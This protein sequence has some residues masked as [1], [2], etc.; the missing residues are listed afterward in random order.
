M[1][2]VLSGRGP[3]RG[4]RARFG[5][6]VVGVLSATLLLLL[7]TPGLSPAR[8]GTSAG[9]KL[10]EGREDSSFLPRAAS[11]PNSTDN[12]T[13][14]LGRMVLLVGL[15]AGALVTLVWSRV[16]V[17]W[18]SHDPSRK[19]QAKERARDAAI[20]SFVLLAAVSGLAWGLARFVL[21]GS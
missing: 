21:T 3:Q 14:A 15:A 19:V 7:L 13:A 6:S 2:T 17:S 8:G 9:V 12:L 16:A 5:G 20:G 10:T 18:F 11:V 1:R 4:D